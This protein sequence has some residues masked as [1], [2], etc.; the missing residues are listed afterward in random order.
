MLCS[1]LTHRIRLTRLIECYFTNTLFKILVYKL[2]SCDL[3]Y[4]IMC[5]I[6]IYFNFEWIVLYLKNLFVWLKLKFEFF[7]FD[8]TW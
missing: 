3:F 8:K 2:I 1:C 5:N 6:E 4:L 7:S